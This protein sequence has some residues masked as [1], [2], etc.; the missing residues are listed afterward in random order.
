MATNGTSAG[1]TILAD[2]APFIALFGGQVTR[3]FLSCSFC[4]ADHILLATAPLGI[5][6]IIDSAISIGGP[7]W[8]KVLVGR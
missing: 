2:L 1:R 7:R 5:I 3:Q 4:W 6:T 8:L